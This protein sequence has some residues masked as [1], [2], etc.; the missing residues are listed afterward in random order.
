MLAV[1]GLGG[2]SGELRED[3]GGDEVDPMGAAPLGLMGISTGGDDDVSDLA[4]VGYSVRTRI[5]RSV[6]E[7]SRNELVSL[8]V[9]G[10][11]L[12]P[13]SLTLP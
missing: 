3:A 11:E 6:G 4:G 13:I 7:R 12:G 2:L 9:R 1:R 5:T 10:K 8:V